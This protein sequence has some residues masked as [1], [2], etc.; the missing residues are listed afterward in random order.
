MDIDISKDLCVFSLYCEQLLVNLPSSLDGKKLEIDGFYFILS[1]SLSMSEFVSESSVILLR[2]GA[3]KVL[4]C[5][6]V[7][8]ATVLVG[9]TEDLVCF[10]RT[11]HTDLLL[12]LLVYA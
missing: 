7:K 4:V 3:S 11:P 2:R 1:T 9:E 5:L 12:L 8:W 10:A 6:S